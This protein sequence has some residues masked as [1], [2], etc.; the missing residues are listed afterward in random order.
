MHPSNALI[1]FSSSSHIKLHFINLR[2]VIHFIFHFV[3]SFRLDFLLLWNGVE[4]MNLMNRNRMGL[5]EI[6]VEAT[7]AEQS[8]AEHQ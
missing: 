1:E 8:K 4:N 3:L 7:V 2:K 6:V 5:S